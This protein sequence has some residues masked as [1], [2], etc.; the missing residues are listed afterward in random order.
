[1]K[2]IFS[3]FLFSLLLLSCKKDKLK[4]DKEIFI[5]KWKWV[6]THSTWR[7]N[8][9]NP[10]TVSILTPTTEGE[11]YSV[12][13]LKKGCL[14]FYKNDEKFDKYRIVFVKTFQL[15]SSGYSGFEMLL[16]NKDENYFFG[17][18]KSDTL[19]IDGYFPKESSNQAC[20][21]NINY[22]VRE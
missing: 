6:Y 12:E 22:F 8:C 2:T 5:G 15:N 21:S 7:A 3:L 1:M 16:N 19:I 13:F 9:D 11:N 17:Y 10:P 4:D 18:I 20:L 14:V